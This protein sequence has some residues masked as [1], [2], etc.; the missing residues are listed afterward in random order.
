MDPSRFKNQELAQPIPFDPEDYGLDYTDEADREILDLAC[1]DTELLGL[2]L[3]AA[4]A[5][6][7]YDLG[8]LKIDKYYQLIDTING[9][10]QDRC[11][12]LGLIMPPK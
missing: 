1:G 7:D 6:Q 8:D 9:H 10:Y 11:I 2:T 4:D 5:R 3:A 12:K